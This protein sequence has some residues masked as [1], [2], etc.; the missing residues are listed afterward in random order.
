M[1]EIYHLKY[2]FFQKNKSNRGGGGLLKVS[3]HI[4][5]IKVNLAVLHD[6]KISGGRNNS[7]HPTK[8]KVWNI[9]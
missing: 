9:C 5:K 2:T 8:K 1:T 6:G 7:I 3:K 4:P